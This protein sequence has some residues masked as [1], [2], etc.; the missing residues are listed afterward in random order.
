MNQAFID[1]ILQKLF[2]NYVKYGVET[3]NLNSFIVE[4]GHDP[5]EIGIF[6]NEKELIR[7]WQIT[8]G[9]VAS[10][11]MKGVNFI[12]PDFYITKTQEVLAYLA[13]NDGAGRISNAISLPDDHGG[14]GKD[15]CTYI[16]GKE[17]ANIQFEP[18]GDIRVYLR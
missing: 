7:S 11:S 12:A 13:L 15:I 17:L 1:Q 3:L 18:R 2:D 8:T 4:A 16:K 9:F 10:I 6:M 14:M 5:R